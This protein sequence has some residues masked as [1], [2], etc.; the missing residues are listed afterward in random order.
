LNPN[1]KTK[2]DY[3]LND[4]DLLSLIKKSKSK[5][6]NEHNEKFPRFIETSKRRIM[7]EHSLDLE[8]EEV[9]KCPSCFSF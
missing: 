5:L 2:K 8:D 9:K 3:L 7:N 6:N 4:G 1:K